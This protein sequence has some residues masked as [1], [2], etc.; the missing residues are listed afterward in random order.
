MRLG[1]SWN[2]RGVLGNIFAGSLWIYLI[3]IFCCS[4]AAAPGL[5]C[6][7]VCILA[8]TLLCCSLSNAKKTWQIK[9]SSE[10]K[11][12]SNA[13]SASVN[14]KLAPAAVAAGKNIFQTKLD[15]NFS[16]FFSLCRRKKKTRD[17]NNNEENVKRECLCARNKDIQNDI[18]ERNLSS[19][20]RQPSAW[21]ALNLG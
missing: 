15:G 10:K 16:Y 20:S 3:F 8:L 21:R 4:Y 2:F 7:V 9:K 19:R 1:F 11:K 12:M 5:C 18:Y 6:V 14:C 17:K 13:T